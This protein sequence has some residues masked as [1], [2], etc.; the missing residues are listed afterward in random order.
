MMCLVC[1]HYRDLYHC[2][3]LLCIVVAVVIVRIAFSKPTLQG[4]LLMKRWTVYTQ[5][6]V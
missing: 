2:H 1:I 6:I 4:Y 3:L 5:R